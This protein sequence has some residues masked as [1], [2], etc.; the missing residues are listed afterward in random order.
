MAIMI[1]RGK[2]RKN[3]IRYVAREV[4]GSDFRNWVPEAHFGHVLFWP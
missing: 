4:N 2:E 1:D 3:P